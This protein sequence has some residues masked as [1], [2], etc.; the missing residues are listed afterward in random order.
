MFRLRF[1]KRAKGLG[2]TL[3][4]IKEL[5]A[6]SHDPRATRADIRQRTLAKIEDVNRRISDLLRIR[7]ALEELA[8]QCDGHGPL[9]GCPILAA[10]TGGAEEQCD[11]VP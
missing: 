10:L 3:H 11:H 7:T 9:E 6:L 8:E 2:F 5:L 4:E 1:I